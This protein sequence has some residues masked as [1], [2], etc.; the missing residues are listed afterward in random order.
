MKDFV[1]ISYSEALH[2]RKEVI[3]Y[4]TSKTVQEA[5]TKTPMLLTAPSP[6]AR[7]T[8]TA[9]YKTP[10][11][12]RGYKELLGVEL[13][14]EVYPTDLLSEHEM[15]L[16][17]SA[18]LRKRLI[19]GDLGNSFTVQ[20]DGSLKSGFELVLPPIPI[21][22]LMRFIRHIH[23]DVLKHYVYSTETTGLHV[24][25]NKLPDDKALLFYQLWNDER[26]IS[27]NIHIIG[28]TPN[29]Y[30]KIGTVATIEEAKRR[31]KHWAVIFRANGAMEVR[32]MRHTADWFKTNCQLMFLNDVYN[33]IATGECKTIESVLDKIFLNKQWRTLDTRFYEKRS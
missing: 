3:K 7:H 22:P 30:C 17:L 9:D 20:Q 14:Y 33:W 25:V 26:F 32:L 29:Q 12:Y 1:E 24:T 5:Y 11:Q 31:K 15:L 4:M 19:L 16:C 10:P 6:S 2:L 18:S 27:Q 28:R 23:Q 21:Q 8:M 13:E